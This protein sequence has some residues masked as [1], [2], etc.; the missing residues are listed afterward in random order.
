M[1]LFRITV[2]SPILNDTNFDNNY[3]VL[4][5]LSKDA[6]THELVKVFL[7]FLAIF[8]ASALISMNF[9]MKSCS[10]YEIPS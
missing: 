4:H 5:G 3:H 8:L 7:S 6:V 1:G 9:F 2:D 10:S